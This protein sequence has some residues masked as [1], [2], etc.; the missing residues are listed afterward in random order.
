MK[1]TG[2]L[3]CVLL[4]SMVLSQNST[5]GV[6]SLTGIASGT[7]IL[8]APNAPLAQDAFSVPLTGFNLDLYAE[9]HSAFAIAG[10]QAASNQQFYSLVVDNIVFSNG[11]TQ[12]NF[13]MNYLYNTNGI[14]FKTTWT[15]VRLNWLA[16][17]TSFQ[18]I[19]GSGR[20]NY[21]WAGS[22]GL[23][24]PF[25]GLAGPVMT[26]SIFANQPASMLAD[27]ECGYTNISP[28]VFDLSC[29]GAANP[30]FLTHLYIMGLQFNPTGGSYTLAASVL[31]Q[32][33]NND[34]EALLNTEFAT[35]AVSGPQMLI[36]AYGSQLAYIK[37]G[38]VITTILDIMTYPDSN[39]AN[40]QY[41]GIY[42]N[43]TLYN[44]AQP[45]RRYDPLVVPAMSN[46][47]LRFY[48]LLNARYQ[49]SGLS[50]FQIATLPSNVTVLNY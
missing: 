6:S 14:N 7:V 8:G 34:D 44:V 31:R 23:S 5:C 27:P 4:C 29:V 40:F 35:A 21:I 20:G 18:T 48:S 37:I 9:V 39:P 16:V 1:L 45:I 26:N 11:N 25:S 2:L 50:S 15:R 19:T 46:E 13:T 10:F 17:S 33:I 24:A 36:N 3:L 47:N 22:V 38:I 49:I 41:S 30:R 43:Y 28:P 12:M 32:S 42:M